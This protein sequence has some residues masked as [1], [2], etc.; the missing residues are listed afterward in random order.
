MPQGFEDILITMQKNPAWQ[1]LKYIEFS[2][3]K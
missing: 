1:I 3:P 2:I